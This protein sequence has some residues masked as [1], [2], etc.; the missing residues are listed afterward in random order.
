ML[1]YIAYSILLVTLSYLFIFLIYCL[2]S[3]I[4][5]HMHPHLHI[6]IN[7]HVYI[8]TCTSLM[9]HKYMHGVYICIDMYVYIYTHVI[10]I[11]THVC[12]VCA[13]WFVKDLE[14]T[15]R[16]FLLLKLQ[17]LDSFTM[18]IGMLPTT[19]DGNKWEIR[20]TWG[21]FALWNRWSEQWG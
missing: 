8:H 16:A 14:T 1:I 17:Q 5:I 10:Y 18:S 20:P 7:L 6:L 9:L 3:G 4:H 12:H 21:L 13:C 15:Y 11:Y 19:W 2:A